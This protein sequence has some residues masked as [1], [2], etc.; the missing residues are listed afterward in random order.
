M[1]TDN[2]SRIELA[3]I[4]DANGETTRNIPETRP[5]KMKSHE[6]AVKWKFLKNFSV[7][8]VLFYNRIKNIIDVGVIFADPAQ[9]TMPNIG[10]DEPGDWNGYWFYKNNEGEIR[11]GGV[12]AS[13][14][15]TTK[16]LSATFSHAMVQVITAS[17]QQIG[18]MYLTSDSENKHF[19]AYPENVSRL[20]LLFYPTKAWALSLNVLYYPN[21]YSP[22]GNRVEGSPV[23]NAGVSWRALENFE[24]SLVAK[25]LT[26]RE[27]PWP[28]NANAGGRDLTEGAPSLEGRTFRLRATYKF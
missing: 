28:M 12:E 25:N 2:F 27:N 14:T 15:Y 24:L 6:L 22:N 11:Q 8:S 26:N 23:L 7:D 17:S 21:W 5:E 1:R 19:R 9:F 13:L 10:N 18:G 16:R 4:P 3:N 20:N